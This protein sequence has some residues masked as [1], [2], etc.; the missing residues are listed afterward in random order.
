MSIEG[1][2]AEEMTSAIANSVEKT[3]PL[4]EQLAK[5]AISD[6]FKQAE[7]KP[8]VRNALND[9]KRSRQVKTSIPLP[10]MQK[11]IKPKARGAR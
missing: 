11:T 3:I 1:E 5:D 6:V 2:T 7:Q 8:S 9:I 10:A 4:A